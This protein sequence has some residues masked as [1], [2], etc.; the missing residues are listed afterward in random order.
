MGGKIIITPEMVAQLDTQTQIVRLIKSLHPEMTDEA[1]WNEIL[2]HV[3]MYVEQ[4]G[5]EPRQPSDFAEKRQALENAIRTKISLTYPE[6][7]GKIDFMQWKE[8]LETLRRAYG[9]PMQLS[10][11]NEREFETWI[12]LSGAVTRWA[13]IKGKKYEHLA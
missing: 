5:G 11:M 7:F 2:I 3:K 4:Y 8:T 10:N 9:L 1:I 6:I 12:R 13:F